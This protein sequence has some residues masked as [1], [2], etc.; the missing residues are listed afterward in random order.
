MLY[1]MNMKINKAYE[2][3]LLNLIGEEKTNKQKTQCD[4]GP[5]H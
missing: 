1:R 4:K 3:T 2:N 5:S